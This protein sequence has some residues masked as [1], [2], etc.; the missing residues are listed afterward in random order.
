MEH[1][2]IGLAKGRRIRG[3]IE[4][5]GG[6]F[7]TRIANQRLG[8]GCWRPD[9]DVGLI[10]I[11]LQFTFFDLVLIFLFATLIRFELLQHR[12]PVF[13]QNSFDR[14]IPMNLKYL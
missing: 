5:S 13:G 1:V 12:S 7:I 4:K 9:A 10:P 11:D 2:G 3:R 14:M 8:L 6:S